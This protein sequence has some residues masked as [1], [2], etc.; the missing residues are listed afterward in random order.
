MIGS[1][2]AADEEQHKLLCDIGAGDVEAAEAHP[3]AH[4]EEEA[5]HSRWTWGKIWAEVA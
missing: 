3:A 5:P 1:K 2:S 4:K